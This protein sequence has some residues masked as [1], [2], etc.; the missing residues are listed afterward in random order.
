M[1]ILFKKKKKKKRT[2]RRTGHCQGVFEGFFSFAIVHQLVDFPFDRSTGVK[3][4]RSRKKFFLQKGCFKFRLLS[5]L[6]GYKEDVIQ[7]ITNESQAHKRGER[8]KCEKSERAKYIS[9]DSNLSISSFFLFIYSSDLLWKSN[10][11]FLSSPSS[12][13]HGL[14]GETKNEDFVSFVVW[15]TERS[16]HIKIL[17]KRNKVEKKK[18][19]CL[20]RFP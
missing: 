8:R 18:F 5:L 3:G 10:F 9:K 11:F 14:Q 12:S 19:W 4:I 13:W 6:S 7:T 15:T 20:Y 16:K 2:V 17:M 1:K